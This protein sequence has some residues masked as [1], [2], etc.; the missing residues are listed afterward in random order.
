MLFIYGSRDGPLAG[1]TGKFCK[2]HTVHYTVYD[3]D[4]DYE[5]TCND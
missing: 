4:Y 2:T 3:Y 5:M 1:N